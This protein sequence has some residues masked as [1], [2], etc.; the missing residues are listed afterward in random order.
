MKYKCWKKTNIV[1]S[2]KSEVVYANRKKGGVL[3]I[4]KSKFSKNKP[5]RFTGIDGRG[6]LKDEYFKD[7]KEAI[8][9]AE[10]Y[11][12]EHDEC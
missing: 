1:T 11:M 10:K 7:T 2:P 8:K 12:K 5:I 3:F 9:R 6:Y 4:Q